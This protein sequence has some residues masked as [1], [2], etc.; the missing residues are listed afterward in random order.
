M[1]ESL[2][3][4]AISAAIR[5]QGAQ[6]Q[7]Y[8]AI[9][10][11]LLLLG[12]RLGLDGD[13]ADSPGQTA[14]QKAPPPPVGLAV[15]GVDGSFEITIT[16]PQDV[17]PPSVTVY[18]NSILQDL[19]NL[20]APMTHQLQ[21]ATSVL[22]DASANVVTYGPFTET[23]QSYQIPNVTLFWRVR[24]S[25]DGTTWNDWVVYSSP[26]TCGPVGVNSGVLRS[27]ANALANTATTPD[28][29][30]PLTQHGTTTQIDVAASVWKAGGQTSTLVI[31]YNS[32]SVDPGSYG[33]F[34]V[35]ADDPARAGGT[36]VFVA[37]SNVANV[38][39]LDGRLYFGSITTASGGGGV[40]GGGG[41]GGCLIGAVLVEMADGSQ[42]LV[43]RLNA[44]DAV[45]GMDGPEKIVSIEMIAGQPCFSLA[46]D[47]GMKLAG[48]SGSHPLKYH[49]AGFERAF[50]I[51][52]GDIL[53]T[54]L[55]AATVKS[56]TF[57]G[58]QTVYRLILDGSRLF[59]S[60]GLVSH[61]AA[62]ALK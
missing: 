22:F 37:S 47:N 13:F 5:N 51:Q 10:R 6:E 61:N 28:G 19:N 53:Q 3:G 57:I 45:L 44:G 27:V 16:L 30:N 34:Y 21:S 2:D 17:R 42:R 54:R 4:V 52:Q 48:C 25:Y 12:S 62:L 23:S 1:S 43:D 46:L 36:V 11:R 24:S 15:V 39:A 56:K 26:T 35:Y 32:G 41:A 14:T 60:D 33:K 31:N 9:N 59:F 8:R 38:T 7:Y 55:G 18:Q 50:E 20:Q 58:A 29:S 49:G 40:G